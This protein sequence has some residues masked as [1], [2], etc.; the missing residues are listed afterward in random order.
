[1]ADMQNSTQTD[2]PTRFGHALSIVGTLVSRLAMLAVLI[3]L[4]KDIGLSDYGIFALVITLGE[5]IEM[6]GSNWYRLLLVR[7]TVN[8]NNPH[9][10]TSDE[11]PAGFT[12]LSLV[13][14]ALVV[15]LVA[16]AIFSPIVMKGT[17]GAFSAAVACY[18]VAF[19][20]FRL[21][22]SLLQAQGRQNLIGGVELLRGILMLTF[23]MGAV[24]FGEAN[25][26]FASFGLILATIVTTVVVFP[27]IRKGLR[28]ILMQRLEAGSFKAIGIP[29]IIA[30]VLTYQIGWLDRVVI[31]H[32]LG[33]ESVGLYVAVMAIARQPVDLFLNALNSQ[34]FPILM[35]RND[36]S[37]EAASRRMTG[38]LLSLCIIGF[39]VAA[40]IIS[41]SDALVQ[42]ALPAFE[43]P[44][45]LSIVPLVSLGSLALGIKH[46]VFDNIFHAY[47]RN[48][49]ML[50]WFA[51]V[52]CGTLILSMLLVPRFGPIGAAI[53]F[54]SGSFGGL[55]S[56][57]ILSH[58]F[59][60]MHWP[61]QA[62]LG[63]F[64]S[65]VLASLAGWS[66]SS[67][68]AAPWIRLGAGSAT[69]GLTYLAALT[70]IL[71]FRI[72]AF[73]SAPWNIDGL[74]GAAS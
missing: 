27:F 41:L 33:P 35:T 63:V 68:D 62:L 58:R 7:Q 3:L 36:S 52:A 34:T 31:Q 17:N 59:C 74:R 5:I 2:S 18:I 6:T 14:L 53:A 10:S 48:W 51:V 69:F 47:G 38:V 42:F 60:P 64:A 37:D 11:A 72:G 50:R 30:T 70:V 73:L 24:K 21:L 61:V 32:W 8:A 22:I 55:A 67:F 13:G 46:F 40:A 26:L 4:P 16:S 23:V 15:S 28:E 65:A 20:S 56:S 9:S 49:I 43:R 29:I 66:C 54:A 45:A 71:N 57:I 19:V 12:L 25:F 39:G 44:T 1:M